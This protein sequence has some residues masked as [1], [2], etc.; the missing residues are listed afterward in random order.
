MNHKIM[1]E[2]HKRDL[3]TVPEIRAGYTVKVHQKIK[4]GAKERIQIFEGLVIKVNSGTGLDKTFT[5]RKIASG[6][7]VE[8]IFPVYS[9]NIAKIEVVKKA[10]VRRAKLYYMRE[11]TGKSARLKETYLKEGDAKMVEHQGAD[12]QSE[13]EP[14]TEA[15]EEGKE[16]EVADG[17]DNK[18]E[19][20]ADKVEEQV[21]GGATEEATTAEETKADDQPEVEVKEEVEAKEETKEE[22]KAPEAEPQEE[23]P[24]V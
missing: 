8:K 10:K 24:K 4:E 2:V 9:K 3:K 7:G 6:V 20:Q 13:S 12:E 16:A 23:N 21:E 11:R 18:E 1:N 15:A 14:K 22:E 17:A 5:V 19:A